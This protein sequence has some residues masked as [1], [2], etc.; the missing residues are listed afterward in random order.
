LYA[1]ELLSFIRLMCVINVFYAFTN[2]HQPIH[3][4]NDN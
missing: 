4:L 1:T 2:V 3:V